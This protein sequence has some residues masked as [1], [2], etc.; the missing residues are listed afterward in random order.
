MAILPPIQPS[1]AP[2][3][4]IG[5]D[6]Q[7]LDASPA[8]FGS[9]IGQ[10]EQGLGQTLGQAGNSLAQHALAMQSMNNERDALNAN[11]AA[12]QQIANRWNKFSSLNGSDAAAGLP[13]FLSDMQQIHKNTLDQLT[14]PEAQMMADRAGQFLMQRFTM[15]ASQRAG[16]EQRRSW[17]QANVSSADTQADQAILF[18]NDPKAVDQ[19]I[20]NGIAKLADAAG[21]AGWDPATLTLKQQQF[22]DQTL[23]RVIMATAGDNPLQAKA[24]LD[25]RRPQLGGEAQALLD[26]QLKPMV[27]AYAAKHV[28]DTIVS[29]G[30]DATARNI[31]T[32]AMSQGVDPTHAL[33]VA[34]LE[35]GLGTAPDAPGNTHTGL[36]QM[37]P[38]EWAAA[39]GQPGERG[40]PAAE[41][42]V[43][44][45]SLPARQAVAD[46]AVG[47]TAEP[48]QAYLVHQQGDAGGAALLKA[49]ADQNVVDALA[50]SYGGDRAKAAQAIT[51]NAGTADMTV[52]QFR[53]L[54]QAKY[55]KAAASVTVPDLT[56]PAR[57][58]ADAADMLAAARSVKSPWDG[59]DDPEFQGMVERQVQARIGQQEYADAQTDRAGKRT[60]MSAVIDGGATDVNGLLQTPQTRDA[61]IN[62]TP[63]TRLAITDLMKRQAGKD[64]PPLNQAAFD[65]YYRLKGLAA[66]DPE[67][68][69]KTNLADP[70]LFNT[71]PHSML[72]ELVGEQ[73]RADS[74]TQIEAQR[75]VNFQHALAVLKP[76]LL[77]AGVSIP[78]K[79]GDK[80]DTYNAFAGRLSEAI[81]SYRAA[82]NGK[83]PSDQ[84]LKGIGATLLT[85]GTI[86]GTGLIWDDSA[87]LFQAQTQG[88]QGAFVPAVP[89]A[90]RAKIT[91]DFQAR[92]G[93]AP[94]PSEIGQVY[95]MARGRR[96]APMTPNPPTNP[97]NT[98]AAATE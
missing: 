37:G 70:S 89:D 30:P 40:N 36:F 98:P 74:K 19:S 24:L 75:A 8:A 82:N 97:M 11:S 47:G 68:F 92:T 6:Y 13:A 10:A 80:A 18:R 91:A 3:L 83:R 50:P 71:L 39:G 88:K 93:R 78:T 31:T 86:S 57:P 62:A 63:E 85:Q 58:Q 26:K 65:T 32:E 4:N 15:A 56:A 87:K 44:V 45:A 72:H 94:T 2:Q 27:L 64:D 9:Q 21:P 48:W 41:A 69:L 51:S 28:T 90:E 7:H 34:Q 81:D 53:D 12:V 20:T 95:M 61:W 54:W 49:P 79:P 17:A 55:A 29:G 1:V 5:D 46:K 33:T 67:A 35:S 23:S 52:G 60:L 77:A 59:S 43:G 16:D 84:D 14:N 25:Q 38:A 96:P 42:R 66:N 73:T 76:D 22:R